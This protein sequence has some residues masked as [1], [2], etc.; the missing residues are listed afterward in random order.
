MFGS[1]NPIP[2][3]EEPRWELW[4][5]VLSAI[6]PTIFS[7]WLWTKLGLIAGQEIL[8]LVAKCLIVGFFPAPWVLIGVRAIKELRRRRKQTG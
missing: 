6:L 8:G 2:I 5:E 7:G 4:L 3:S 1:G